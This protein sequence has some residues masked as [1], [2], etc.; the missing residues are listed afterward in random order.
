LRPGGLKRNEPV[1]IAT[2][3]ARKINRPG[4]GGG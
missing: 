3:L 4:W 1:A 2:G